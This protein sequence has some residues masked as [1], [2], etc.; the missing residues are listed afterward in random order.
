MEAW[1][2]DVIRRKGYKLLGKLDL[3]PQLRSCLYAKYLISESQYQLLVTEYESGHK[4]RAAEMCLQYIPNA[5][6]VDECPFDLFIGALEETVELGGSSSNGDVAKCLLSAAS[7]VVESGK[8]TGFSHS[9]S[10]SLVSGHSL[11]RSLP[12]TPRKF[13]SEPEINRGMYVVEHTHSKHIIISINTLVPPAH[14]HTSQSHKSCE[15]RTLHTYV[16]CKA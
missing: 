9:R 11:D 3:E 10:Q 4:M 13:H 6:R 7:D 1:K 16:M 12:T 8:L 2:R 5:G 14:K 15:K